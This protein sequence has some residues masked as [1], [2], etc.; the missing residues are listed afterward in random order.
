[1]Q[2]F[3]SWKSYLTVPIPAWVFLL[4]F[5]P[6]LTFAAPDD[7]RSPQAIT[8]PY[9]AQLWLDFETLSSAEMQGRKPGTQGSEMARNYI[10]EQYAS[11]GLKPFMSEPVLQ[12][13]AANTS[14]DQGAASEKRHHQVEWLHQ[15]SLKSV[16]SRDKLGANIVG[17]I[18]GQRH[19]N[20]YIVL[21]AHYD[22]IGKKRGKIYYGA[23]D[24]ASGVA[25][26]IYIAR[27]LGQLNPAHSV[28]FVATDY[29]EA[30]LLG[31]KAFVKDQVIAPHKILININ[32]DM[33]AQPGKTW[34]LYISGTRSQPQ[35]KTAVSSVIE[36]APICVKMGLDTS[37]WNHNRTHRIDWRKASD[38]WAFARNDIAWLYLGVKDY[39]YY[40]T[41]KDTV[42]KIPANFYFGSAN[43]GFLLVIALEKFFLAKK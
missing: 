40:H 1:M 33:I 22:H 43:A 37:S 30:G 8:D 17:W 35:F 15:F 31:A 28:V 27:K 39:R 12:K 34:R 24:N 9:F 36:D 29:E 11:A 21:T 38:H 18:P 16:F 3:N 41:P 19:P 5:V 25:A 13:I 14:A 4:I 7:C 20:K 23:N 32:L 26:M 10:I 42:D 2:K 6:R